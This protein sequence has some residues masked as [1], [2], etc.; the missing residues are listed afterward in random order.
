[1]PLT[2]ASYSPERTTAQIG[3]D[4]RLGPS[5]VLFTCRDRC[6]GGVIALSAERGSPSGAALG[7][8]H[9][10]RRGQAR[11]AVRSGPCRAAVIGPAG[12][13]GPAR[14][15]VDSRRQWPGWS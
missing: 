7:A 13:P 10:G 11:G 4:A 15:A 14:A 12:L 6:S 2:S 3:G 1:L 8:D 9:E 5:S